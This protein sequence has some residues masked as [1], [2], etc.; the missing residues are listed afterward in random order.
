MQ[1]ALLFLNKYTNIGYITF[2]KI[3][4]YLKNDFSGFFDLKYNDFKN[5]GLKEES[6]LNII[7]NF[8]IYNY[9]KELNILDKFNIKI[10]CINDNNYPKLLKNIYDPPFLFYYKG[11]LKENDD[12]FSVIGTR[13]YTEYGRKV[14]FDF[15]EFLSNYFTITSG[16][17]YGIDTFAHQSCVKSNKRTVAVVGCGLDICYPSSNNLLFKEILDKDGAIISEFYLGTIPRRENFP[18]RNRI[19]SGMSFGLLVVEAGEKSGTLITANYSLEQGREVFVIPGSV[20]SPYSV[21]TNF[22]I[23]NGANFITKP[24]EILPFFKKDIKNISIKK[25][26]N[27]NEKEKSVY[28]LISSL[29]INIEVISC[30]VKNLNINEINSILVMLEIKGLVK[31]IGGMNYVVL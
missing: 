24:E 9:E 16:F 15:S 20:Y 11:F 22:L 6:V 25:D 29:P 28:N 14:A 8:K 7:E 3:Q 30:S 23:K 12:Y 10:C 2:K 5:I 4:D 18:R 17:A 21:G 13:K 1:K 19:I 31:N 26:I 27:L